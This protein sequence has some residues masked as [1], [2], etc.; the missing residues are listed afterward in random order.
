MPGKLK[1]QN[2]RVLASKASNLDYRL[3]IFF[4]AQEECRIKSQFSGDTVVICIFKNISGVT[5]A[6]DQNI[7]LDYSIT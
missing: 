1:K 4:V 6:L 2:F 3:D 5:L 7:S